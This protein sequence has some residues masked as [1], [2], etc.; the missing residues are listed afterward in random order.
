MV[1]TAPL[2]CC[3]R[4]E[5]ERAQGLGLHAL[6]A[7][8]DADLHLADRAAHAELAPNAPPPGRRRRSARLPERARISAA[9]TSEP[10]SFRE[11]PAATC[12]SPAGLDLAEHVDRDPAAHA[13]IIFAVGAVR[14]LL[15]FAQLQLDL[16]GQLGALPQQ[17][18]DG[19]QEAGLEGDQLVHAGR[20]VAE[21]EE[22][23]LVRLHLR[24]AER[25]H[26]V[27][28]DPHRGKRGGVFQH[29]AFEAGFWAGWPAAVAGGAERAPGPAPRRG[30]PGAA[31]SAGLARE[32]VQSRP[33]ANQP[34]VSCRDPTARE[35]RSPRGPLLRNS[36]FAFFCRSFPSVVPASLKSTSSSRRRLST[37]HE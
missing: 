24:H 18:L 27:G 30:Q 34:N 33:K 20:Q 25:G 9:K 17:Q 1:R 21:A 11:E 35:A 16:L 6:V 15:L 2:C 28:I 22:A 19:G 14:H 37:L 36:R 13:P 7:A 12:S 23:G 32:E 8:A 3:A 4:R 10:W 29:A 5:A 31:A 26:L